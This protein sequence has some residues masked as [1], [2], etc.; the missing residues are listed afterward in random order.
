MSPGASNW[1][2]VPVHA[3]VD[4]PVQS[5]NS[6]CIV[7]S[8]SFLFFSFFIFCNFGI[9]RCPEHKLNDGRIVMRFILLPPEIPVPE[10]RI[11]MT[12]HMTLGLLGSTPMW[13]YVA[14]QYLSLI[15]I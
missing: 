1:S 14:A 7:F 10:L 6:S 15:H 5:G 12:F 8:F 3:F 2:N 9:F 13:I 11:H 4:A